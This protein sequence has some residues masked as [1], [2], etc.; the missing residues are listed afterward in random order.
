MPT[1]ASPDT[2]TY[3]RAHTH[4]HIHQ[5]LREVIEAF[6]QMVMSWGTGLAEELLFLVRENRE[7]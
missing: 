3:S 1:I 5:A 2:H 7:D 6:I 4:T